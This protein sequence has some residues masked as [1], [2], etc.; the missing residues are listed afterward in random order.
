MRSPRKASVSGTAHT[1]AECQSVTGRACAWS[2]EQLHSEAERR[3]K[4]VVAGETV[5]VCWA[6]VIAVSEPGSL[7]RRSGHGE[8]EV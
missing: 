5:G 6:R 1:A 4:R 7:V 3:C 2:T 8:R